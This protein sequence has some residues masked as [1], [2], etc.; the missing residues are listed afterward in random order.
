MADSPFVDALIAAGATGLIF[1]VLL[2]CCHR[3]V[4][5]ARRR[6]KRAYMIGATLAPFIAL[7]NVVDPDFRIVQEAKRLKNRE[8]DNPGDPPEPDFDVIIP[9]PVAAT[10]TKTTARSRKVVVPPPAIARPASV[11]IVSSVLGLAAVLS[12]LTLTWALFSDARAAAL[13]RETLSPIEWSSLYAMSVVLLASMVGFFRLRKSSVGLFCGYLAGGVALTLLSTF[14]YGQRPYF[15][16][17]VTLLVSV[18]LAIAVLLYMFRLKK[19][20]MLA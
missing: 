6:K 19:R 20:G 2:Y 8:D 3:V 5:W 10:H 18:P 16:P 13:V 1:A 17:Q 12:S 7:G 9:A 11:W 15:D 4:L 14:L